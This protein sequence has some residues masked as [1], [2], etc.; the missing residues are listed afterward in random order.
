MANP[1]GSFIWYEL[2]SRDAKRALDFYTRVV[3]WET[4]ASDDAG[5]TYHHLRARDG[6]DVGGGMEMPDG[7]PPGWLGYIGVNDV[8]GQVKAIEQAGGSV[9]VPP[10]DIPNVGRFALVADPQHVPFYV[11]RGDHEE[12]STAFAADRP[13]HFGWNELHAQDGPAA[14]DFYSGQFGWR[15]GEGMDMGAMGIYQLFD[16]SDGTAAGAVMTKTP[17]MPTAMW[18]PYINVDDIDAAA[19]RVR[20]NGGSVAMGPHDV[21]GGSRIIQGFDPE[22]AL[23]ALV[24]PPKS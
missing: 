4:H 18:L 14:F 6:E 23:F 3:G 22:G 11:M 15:K 9:H 16:L 2:I 21:P 24:A 12:A 10:T 8:D 19:Q 20:D 13:G 7:P 17:Q 1:H 5:F